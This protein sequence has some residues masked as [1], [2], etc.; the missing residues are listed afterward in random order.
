ML[1]GTLVAFAALENLLFGTGGLYLPYLNPD[2]TTGHLEL[3]LN[4]EIHRPKSDP[5]QVLIV[6]DSRTGFFARYANAL[7]SELGYTF[8]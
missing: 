4:N 1:A 5:N 2:S 8:A 6:G 7:H 3:V